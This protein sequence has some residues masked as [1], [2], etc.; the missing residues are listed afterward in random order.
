VFVLEEW[1]KT[2][3]GEEDWWKNK[4]RQITDPKDYAKTVRKKWE[5]QLSPIKN[6]INGRTAIDIGFG[7]YTVFWYKNYR[8]MT[9][10]DPMASK[11]VKMFPMPPGVKVTEASL[12]DFEPKT[13]YDVAFLMSAL[14][15]LNDLESSMKKINSMLS[16]NGVFV[17]TSE[18]YNNVFIRDYTHAFKRYVDELHMHHFTKNDVI[19]LMEKNGMELV[20]SGKINVLKTE[21]TQYTVKPMPFFSWRRL[22]PSRWHLIT[23][24]IPMSLISMIYGL[25]DH[26]N[27]YD[28]CLFVFRK[29]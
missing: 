11:F 20:Y 29:L 24:K 8:K 19:K 2:L 5:I 17:L 9:A 10:I 14:N 16:R 26:E 28:E 25:M 27:V 15:H 22:R 1:K 13:T 23:A 7:G 18:C 12:E 4:A 3:E 6:L 21:D